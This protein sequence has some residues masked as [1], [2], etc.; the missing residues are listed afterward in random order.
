LLASHLAQWRFI[1]APAWRTPGR[2]HRTGDHKSGE[3]AR[4]RN[5]ADPEIE[6]LGKPWSDTQDLSVA[7]AE[8]CDQ[9]RL[10]PLLR[11]HAERFGAEIRLN[12][13]LEHSEQDEAGVRCTLMDR[14]RD[15]RSV[16]EAEWMIAAD[17]ISSAVRAQLDVEQLGP[18]PL[19]HWMNLIVRSDLRPVLQG[20][21]IMS[22]FVTD[23]N[24]SLIPRGD[25]WL[26]AMPYR[27]D[28]GERPED[29]D[30][31]HTAELVRHAAGRPDVRVELFDAR[32]W[33]VAAYVARRLKV[34]R[35][36]LVGDAAHA[37][38]PTGGF[39][40]NTGIHDVHNLAWKLALVLSGWAGPKLL[41]T[42]DP[43]RR[44][45]AERTLGQALA[46]LSRWFED[47]A[48]RLPPAE[49]VLDDLCVIFGQC[50][51]AGALLPEPE[52]L[53][54][55][56]FENPRAPSGRPGV[57]APHF[58][59][60]R[61][62]EEVPIHDLVGRRFTLLSRSPAWTAAA[63]ELAKSRE[64]LAAICLEATED[65][66][67]EAAID[68]ARFSALYGIATNG[69]VLIRPD[70]VVAWRSHGQAEAPLQ[71]LSQV[72]KAVCF[73]PKHQTSAEAPSGN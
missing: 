46:R 28:Q 70:G 20:K 49:A 69:A 66:E 24:C 32:A 31:H 56:G 25:R 44:F 10:E 67:G 54:E 41:D 68:A 55:L 73:D 59:L 18:G 21:R 40:G 26:L 16:V 48:K 8:T 57:R 64:G 52:P 47:W 43:E 65:R 63:T 14:G 33:T 23:V 61:S 3:I 30:Q 50:Y 60:M 27:P 53:P 72:T 51:P 62:G 17:G 4:A 71:I 11:T 34:G 12:T 9:N 38:P 35:V 2:A 37:I 19:Q 22:C 13:V 5:L 6:F 1:A 15:R 58:T 7:T 36:F 29:F 45:V 42:Y 39:G